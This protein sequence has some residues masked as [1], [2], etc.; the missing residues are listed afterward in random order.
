MGKTG[1]RI[2]RLVSVNVGDLNADGQFN[3]PGSIYAAG[4]AGD[5]F[6][7]LDPSTLVAQ[8]IAAIGSAFSDYSTVTLDLSGVPAGLT[9]SL[10]PADYTG[11]FDRSIARNFGFDLTFTGVIPGTYSFNVNALVDGAIVATESDR[12]VV[13]GGTVVPEPASLAV[14]G[15]GLLGFGFMRRRCKS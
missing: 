7:S 5:Y 9:A 8:I 10:V 4:A 12:I 1:G 2:G 3:G 14:L 6:V 11:S 13:G 15:A